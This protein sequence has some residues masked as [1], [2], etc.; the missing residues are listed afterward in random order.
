MKLDRWTLFNI[1]ECDR[2]LID[3]YGAPDDESAILKGLPI[4]VLEQVRPTIRRIAE[5]TGKKLRVIYRGPRYDLCRSWCRRADARA[6]S[7]YWR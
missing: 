1:T 5:L 3:H 2:Q 6:F 4:Q 7:V